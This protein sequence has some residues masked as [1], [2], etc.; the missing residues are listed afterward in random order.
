MERKQFLGATAMAGAALAMI[1]VASASTTTDTS[2]PVN[3]GS[4]PRPRPSGSPVAHTPH[5]RASEIESAYRHVERVIEMLATDKNDYDGH[6]IPALGYLNQ[7]AN[8]LEQ[9]IAYAQA[10]PSTPPPL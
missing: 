5:P 10:H 3:C 1:G 6:R 9:A 4:E 2:N 7:A 8:E